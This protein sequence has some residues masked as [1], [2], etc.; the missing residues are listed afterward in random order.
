MNGEFARNGPNPRFR[1]SGGYHWFDGDGMVHGVRITAGSEAIYSNRY[2]RTKKLAVEEEAGKPVQMKIGD[3]CSRLALA[4]IWL[5]SLKK[6]LGVIPD[7][8]AE[9]EGTAN[10]SLVYHAG[11]LMALV[12]NALPYALRVMCDGVIETM[13]KA[14]FEGEMKNPFT[15]HPKKDPATGKLYAFG[16]QVR[17][18]QVEKP[19]YVTFYVLDADGKL[20]RQARESQSNT[21]PVDVPRAIMMHDFHITENYAIFM[22]LPLLFNK[23]RVLS[24]DM[25]FVFDKSQG[26]RMGV[27]PLDAT[28]ASGMRWFDLPEVFFAFHVLN[29]WEEQVE[30]KSSAGGAAPAYHSAVKIIT[31]DMFELEL[32]ST[33]VER[34]LPDGQRT[35]PH[36]TTLNLDTGEALRAKLSA[37][38]N[39]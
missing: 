18:A 7:L 6:K 33:K 30:A 21:F 2:V 34:D 14:T 26:A 36:V 17:H 12:E 13:G 27:L 23:E 29:A 20:E 31:S 15:A 4:K 10:T 39:D 24:G 5:H 16:Y 38:A 32:D 8:S 28:D 9:L 1:P 11:R 35:D 3:F 37:Q 22:D 25:P 19:P